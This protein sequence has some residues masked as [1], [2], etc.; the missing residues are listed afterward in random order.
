MPIYEFKCKRCGK[1]FEQLTFSSS[2]DTSIECPQC[3][4]MDV[5]RLFS[6]FS[7]VGGSGKLSGSSQN[8]GCA[9]RSPF[10]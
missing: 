3:G 2:G 6:S 4:G 8:T 7:S 1:T 9:S 10:S 5:S